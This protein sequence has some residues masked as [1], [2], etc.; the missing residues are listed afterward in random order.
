VLEDAK[1]MFRMTQASGGRYFGP[2]VSE[3]E[4][5]TELKRS[6]A[7]ALG[8]SKEE[9]ELMTVESWFRKYSPSW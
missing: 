3:K 1:M 7:L 6:A 5:A 8:L 2:E 9:Q 4:T